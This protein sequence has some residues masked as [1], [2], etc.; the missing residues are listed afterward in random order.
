[1][2]RTVYIENDKRAELKRKINE[3]MKSNLIEEK[4]Y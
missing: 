4:E 3:I 1:L 2:A